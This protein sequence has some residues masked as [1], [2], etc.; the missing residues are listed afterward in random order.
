MSRVEVGGTY[1]NNIAQVHVFNPPAAWN[2]LFHALFVDVFQIRD[3]FTLQ[4]EA[5]HD[6]F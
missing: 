1:F 3:F 6:A 2:I 5:V 4:L